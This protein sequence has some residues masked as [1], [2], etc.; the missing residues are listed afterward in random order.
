MFFRPAG[1]GV[2]TT[3][4]LKRA[5]SI[6]CSQNYSEESVWE[7]CV[8]RGCRGGEGEGG[9]GR[10]GGHLHFLNKALPESLGRVTVA[11]AALGRVREPARSWQEA[12]PLPGALAM[13]VGWGVVIL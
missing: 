1:I 11:A 12:G 13:V 7:S 9:G 6:P 10:C 4:G 5:P 2:T 3:L 8:C